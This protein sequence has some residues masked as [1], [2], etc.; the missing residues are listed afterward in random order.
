[1]NRWEGKVAVVTGSASGIGKAITCALLERKIIVVGLDIQNEE[2][3]KTADNTN[4][5]RNG[6]YPLRC[7]VTR[8]DEVDDAF[9]FV[10]EKLH[11][12]DIM[13]NNA[14]VIDYRRIIE[15]D[16]KTFEKLLNINVLAVAVCIN[17]AV[18]SMRKKNVEGHVFNIN[19]MV[20]HAIPAGHPCDE[21]GS[22]GWNLYP[23]TKHASVAITETVRHELRAVEA[24]IRITSICPGIVKTEIASNN[25]GVVK[26]VYSNPTLLPEDIAD[27]LIYALGTRPEVQIAE[28]VIQIRG[29]KWY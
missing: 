25:A 20:G 28:M 7:D 18:R 9:L 24:P 15:S 14:G 2:D 8:E 10:E 29:E 13:V 1:M 26:A 16:R 11:G 17:R 19:S 21:E 23:A 12:V 3:T 6:Y 27:A 22:N 4:N 5:K